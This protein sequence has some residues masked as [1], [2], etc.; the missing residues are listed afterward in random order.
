LGRTGGRPA[1]FAVGV[2]EG[3]F[4]AAGAAACPDAGPFTDA[5]T[6][7]AAA[8]AAVTAAGCA[9]IGGGPTLTEAFCSTC[10]ESFIAAGAH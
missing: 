4:D 5:S 10:G 3:V 8:L 1:D 2:A 6:G 7:A 9:T